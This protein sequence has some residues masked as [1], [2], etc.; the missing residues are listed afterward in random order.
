MRAVHGVAEVRDAEAALMARLPDGALMQRAAAGLARRCAAMVSRVYGARV[1]LLV[2]SGDNG[3]DAL[4]AGARL[5]RRGARVHALLTGERAH[6]GGLAAL[7]AAGGRVDGE[8]GRLFADAD[9]VVDGVLGIG[10]RGA[11]REPAAGWAAA[12]ARGRASVVAVDIPSGVDADSGRVAGAA[13]RADV[14]VTFGTRKPGLVMSPG[15]SYAGLVECVDIGLQLPTAEL[16]MLDADDVAALIPQPNAASNKYSRGVVGVVAGSETYTGAAVLA[17]GGAIRAGAGMVRYFGPPH[18]AAIVRQNW[19]EAVVTEVA[20]GADPTATGQVQAWVV[21]PGLGTGEAA[22]R[23]V[24]AVLRTDV[25]V[26]VDADGLTVLNRHRD[27]LAGRTAPTLLTPHA[28]EFA[29]LMGT[30]RATVEA[31][32]LAWVSRA[33]A[34]LGVTVLLKG[35]TTVIGDPSGRVRINSTGTP[36]LATAGSGDVLSGAT[37]ALLAGGLGALDAGSCGA[38]LHGLAGQLAAGSPGAPIAATDV[39]SHW[40]AAVSAVRA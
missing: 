23:V 6:P 24:A 21:G 35:A 30:E 9:L 5:A 26:L 10:G 18:P 11:L 19:P 12:A 20:E 4:Y 31:D 16:S 1:V 22:E 2:G 28:G 34:E 15:A 17:T 32:G 37:G 14:T 8:A 27:W 13:V 40:P 38:F 29:R 3:G 33:V 7:L 39:V 36:V 25:R